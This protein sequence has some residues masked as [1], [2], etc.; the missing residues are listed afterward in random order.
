MPPANR[1]FFDH[2][3]SYLETLKTH[4]KTFRP[5]ISPSVQDDLAYEDYEDAVE[6]KEV[7]VEVMTAPRFVSVS[8]RVE[9][10]MGDTV[11]LPCIVDR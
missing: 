9:V 8:Q 2:F 6:A 1:T 7:E 11:R 10:N 3:E 4:F 5:L